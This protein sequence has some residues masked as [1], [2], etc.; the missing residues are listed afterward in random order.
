V[1]RFARSKNSGE[2]SKKIEKLKEK[3]LKSRLD[4]NRI[5]D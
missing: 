3:G 5:I 1:K 2:N 4:L